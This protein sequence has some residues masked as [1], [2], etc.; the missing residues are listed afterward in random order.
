[1]IVNKLGRAVEHQEEE[2]GL[3]FIRQTMPEL[4]IGN[5]FVSVLRFCEVIHIEII[6]TKWL[7]SENSVSHGSTDFLNI[8]GSIWASWPSITSYSR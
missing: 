8:R 3:I 5:M 1:M 4:L 7:S 2:T 6:L